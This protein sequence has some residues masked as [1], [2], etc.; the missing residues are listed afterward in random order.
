[1][2]TTPILLLG[3]GRM[4]GALI[5]GWRRAGAYAASE[6]MLLDPN[7]SAEALA[8]LFTLQPLPPATERLR[9]RIW[10]KVKNGQ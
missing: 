5:E 6:L 4:G 10:S 7:P 9:T 3:A 1:M 2:T 8:S